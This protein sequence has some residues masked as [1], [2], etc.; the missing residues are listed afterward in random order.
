MY[1]V[2]STET[3]FFSGDGGGRLL[4]ILNLRRGANSKR[5][6]YLK[7]GANSS[8]YGNPLFS[9]LPYLTSTQYITVFQLLI[10]P[11]NKPFTLS[12]IFP[13]FYRPSDNLSTPLPIACK[14]ALCGKR[15]GEPACVPLNFECHLLMSR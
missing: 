8:I 4:Q 14:N 7:L 15:E 3:H 12:P 1:I 2:P 9:P 13:T 10:L 6:A 5:G 11:Q